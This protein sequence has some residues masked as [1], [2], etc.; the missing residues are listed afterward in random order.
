MIELVV[1]QSMW[2]GC[3]DR[4]PDWFPKTVVAIICKKTCM[5][6]IYMLCYYV[7]KMNLSANMS[8][9]YDINRIT[10]AGI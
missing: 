3:V 4:V 1:G 5:V 6:I 2:A 10:K 7:F 9:N 8:N